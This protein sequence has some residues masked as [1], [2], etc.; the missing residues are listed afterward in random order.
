M[1]NEER[2]D[3]PFPEANYFVEAEILRAEKILTTG[4]N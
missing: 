3:H 2:R 1:L 4:S